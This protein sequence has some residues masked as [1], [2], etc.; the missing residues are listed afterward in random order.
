MR[1]K[2][3]KKLRKL[4]NLMMVGKPKEETDKMYKK[5]KKIHKV[6]KGEL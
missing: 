1:N 4:A 3:A 2:S 5:M 6:N